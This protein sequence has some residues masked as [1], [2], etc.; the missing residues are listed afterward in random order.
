M[1]KKF[2]IVL[3]LG[4]LSFNTSVHG[5]SGEVGVSPVNTVRF[6]LGVD[7]QRTFCLGGGL[8]VPGGDGV[9]KYA[10]ARINS[11]EYDYVVLTQDWH[12]KDHQSLASNHEGAVPNTMGKL[13]GKD[14]MLWSDH[15]LAGTEDAKF[16][17][18]LGVTE[19]EITDLSYDTVNKDDVP[20]HVQR[21]GNH[22]DYDSYSG[23]QD[24]GGHLTGLAD[25]M[26]TKMF[27]KTNI[28]VDVMG[29]ATDYCVA[30][31]V[32]DLLELVGGNLLSEQ[33]LTVNL[34][35]DGC[36]GIFAKG[37]LEAVL[38][39]QG[40]GVHIVGDLASLEA[41]ALTGGASSSL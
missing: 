30:Y 16:H 34:H 28:I 39:M 25:Y 27:G 32:G 10:K 20:I 35:L 1:Y 6:L 14:H 19:K 7:L 26:Q 9:M 31:T 29:L 17:E 21:K 15:G 8:P 18:L 11:G 41:A 22:P 23:F 12:P 36:R 38:S 2:S 5:A 3:L 33:T 37:S 4:L 40:K 13:H 24:E